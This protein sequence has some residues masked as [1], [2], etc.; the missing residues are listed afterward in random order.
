MSLDYREVVTERWRLRV[1]TALGPD[2]PLVCVP[3]I[4]PRGDQR[5]LRCTQVLLDAGFRVEIIWEGEGTASTD[6]AVYERLIPKSRSFAE[7][8]SKL[9]RLTLMAF[10]SGARNWHIHDFYML[11]S[12][13]L[14]RMRGIRTIYDVHEY[15][16]EYYS[17]KFPSPFRRITARAIST[18]EV[19][20]ARKI[21]GANVVAELMS[22][23]F[24]DGAV[25]LAVSPNYPSRTP[26]SY[27]KDK[28]RSGA[29]H[30]GTLSSTYG[31]VQLIDVA[32]HLNKLDPT[33]TVDLVKK[34]PNK[35]TEDR[36]HELLE[37]SDASESVRL[38][39]PVRPSEVP[40]LLS[41]YVVGLSTILDAGQNDIAIPTKLYEYVL[42]GLTTVGTKRTAQER[43]LEEWGRADLFSDD[44][45]LGMALAI[46]AAHAPAAIEEAA[47]KALLAEEYLQWEQGPA[48]SLQRLVYSVF[49]HPLPRASS[50]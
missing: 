31:M 39:P 5:I 25:P 34:F 47:A 41:R 44:D 4:H 7:R 35:A 18:F 1:P 3:T 48:N 46:V 9:G 38:L 24:R 50:R 14:A 32:E 8:I 26:V 29:I 12:A 43:F 22:A 28:S 42:G 45:A 20:V 33:L 40:S 19:H 37:T 30:I 27:Y 15:Y 36:F 17:S 16:P 21:G 49:G 6:V 13:L 10:R 2:S 23:P 11:P